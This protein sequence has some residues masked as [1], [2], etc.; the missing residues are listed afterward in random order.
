MK[1]FLNILNIIGFIVLCLFGLAML[2]VFVI[3]IFNASIALINGLYEINQ[4]LGDAVA[5][6]YIALGSWWI[7]GMLRDIYVQ[8]KEKN[9]GNDIKKEV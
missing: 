3:S 1:R 8:I 5:W 4:M 9:N 7:I 2:G 6:A